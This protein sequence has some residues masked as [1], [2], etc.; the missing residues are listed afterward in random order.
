VAERSDLAEFLRARRAQ[1]HPADVGLPDTGRRRTPGLRREEVAALAGVSI[2]YLVRL[3]QGRDTN[4]SFEVLDALATALRLTADERDHLLGMAM[5]RTAKT[6][7]RNEDHQ[8]DWTVPPGVL[9]ILERLDPTPALV[10]GPW[11]DVLVRNPSWEWLV[12][13]L[14]MLDGDPPNLVRYMVLH[15][16]AREVYPDWAQIAAEQIGRLRSASVRWGELPAVA[17]LVS[18]LRTSPFFVERWDAHAVE[19]KRR[20][21]KVI[22]HPDG[23]LR[24]DFEVLALPDQHGLQLVTWL[25][26]DEATSA[27]FDAAVEPIRPDLRVVGR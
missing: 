11:L 2:D 25:P 10:I 18:E 26:A 1:L 7:H 22:R 4:P 20:G 6:I 3:E 19:E 5:C 16:R 15:P 14:G 24:V 17:E 21:T 9:A 27:V 12:R 13:P 23:D 8:P